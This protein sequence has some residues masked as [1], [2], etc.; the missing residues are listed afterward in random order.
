MIKVSGPE[1][2]RGQRT[3]KTFFHFGTLPSGLEL[4]HWSCVHNFG[5]CRG[6]EILL[7][8]LLVR[9]VLARV[10]FK[11]LQSPLLSAVHIGK[12][13]KEL[14]SLLSHLHHV[15][16]WLSAY[17]SVKKAPV[18]EGSAQ[19][20]PSIS[21]IRVIWLY[22]LVPGKRGRPRKSSTAMQPSDHI[23]IAAV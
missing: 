15:C 1:E 10:L 12:R 17:R 16:W 18:E 5:Q 9:I 19:A 20:Y 22:S 21:T 3:R 13:V 14:A 6:L 7:P 2:F 11:A 8:G 4:W 23:S